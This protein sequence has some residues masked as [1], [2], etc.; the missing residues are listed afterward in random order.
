MAGHRWKLAGATAV[1]VDHVDMSPRATTEDRTV[2]ER[3]DPV[4]AVF[5]CEGA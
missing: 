4:D 1:R 3:C 5:S 2:R